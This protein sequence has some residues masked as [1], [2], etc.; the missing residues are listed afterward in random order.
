M[1]QL[2]K[3]GNCSTGPICR[4]LVKVALFRVQ[5]KSGKDFGFG[6]IGQEE[7]ILSLQMFAE[8]VQ[9]LFVLISQALPQGYH[10]NFVLSKED[11]DVFPGVAVC[12]S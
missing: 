3:C 5:A 2:T 10:H 9:V 6:V 8:L 7:A 4:P 1:L 12:S 11:P